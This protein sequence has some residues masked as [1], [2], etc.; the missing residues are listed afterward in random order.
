[1][2]CIIPAPSLE[3]VKA[4]YEGKA[5]LCDLLLG[6]ILGMRDFLAERLQHLTAGKVLISKNTNNSCFVFRYSIAETLKKE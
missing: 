2:C 3:N 6:N 1:M 4:I 5:L